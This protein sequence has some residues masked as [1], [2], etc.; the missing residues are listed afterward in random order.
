MAIRVK[1][2]AD[3][4]LIYFKKVSMPSRR[5]LCTEAEN[6]TRSTD[7]IDLSSVIMRL[8]FT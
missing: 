5:G 4:E 1:L 2:F 3:Q 6:I 8:I 7:T